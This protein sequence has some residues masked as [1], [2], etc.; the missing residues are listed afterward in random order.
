MNILKRL[1]N[2]TPTRTTDLVKL[3]D[4][5]GLPKKR[6][7]TALTA[8]G[9]PPLW[10]AFNII[11]E[12]VSSTPFRVYRTEG[13]DTRVRAPEHPA[14]RLIHRRAGIT[15]TAR[16][17]REAMTLHALVHGNG[18]ARI[19]RDRA[20]RP[21]D[22]ELLK[23]WPHTFPVVEYTGL[24]RKLYY[25]TTHYGA[26]GPTKAIPAEDV[27][28]I[29]GL[30]Y[31]GVQGLSVLE[32]LE[33]AIAGGKATQ[34]YATLYFENGGNVKGYLQMP[35][36]VQPSQKEDIR[37]DWQRMTTG[38]DN[39]HGVALLT[40]GMEYKQLTSDAES[41]QLID[42]RRF[43]IT[44][45]SNIT[46]VRPHDL[47]D[48]SGAAYNSLEWENRSHIDRAIGPW[49]TRWEDECD[50]KLLTEAEKR[51]DTHRCRFD[52]DYLIKVGLSEQAEA[53]H[54]YRECG[55]YTVNEVR[56]RRNMPS[57]EDGDQRH[58]PM[59]WTDASNPTHLTTQDSGD[60]VED[61]QREE[62]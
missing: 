8:L 59:N 4:E 32:I 14:N 21:R 36:N 47:G 9:V 60:N 57:V 6:D 35:G 38:D 49:L 23:P 28:H 3:R 55:V 16:A 17:L 31:D 15:Q 41:S 22:L 26:N 20:M 39:A 1:F 46:G 56:R 29:H 13:D 52:R 10:R 48:Q 45:V 53:D 30:S 44:D 25:V 50:D 7:I 33:A 58:I 54:K 62:E 2:F 43:T 34:E 19:W 40:G 12:D 42:A 37:K 24:E 51:G 5:F 18:Y 11:C 61:D 27:L